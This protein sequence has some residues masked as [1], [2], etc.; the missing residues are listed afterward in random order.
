VEASKPK[1]LSVGNE[2]NRWLE[3]YGLEGPNGFENWVSLYEETV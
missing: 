2:V 3:A 1:Y